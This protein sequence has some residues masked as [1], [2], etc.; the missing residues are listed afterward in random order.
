MVLKLFNEIANLFLKDKGMNN[1][2][3]LDEWLYEETIGFKEGN[4]ISR[5]L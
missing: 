5:L 1:E 3:F 2:L 4:F